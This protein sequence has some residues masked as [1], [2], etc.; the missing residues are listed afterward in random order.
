MTSLPNATEMVD[1]FSTMVEPENGILVPVTETLVLSRGTKASD[2]IARAE[3]KVDDG[4][5]RLSNCDNVGREGLDTA[6][7][8]LGVEIERAR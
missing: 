4:R 3:L 2:A 1:L 5:L 8:W 7:Y 6:E